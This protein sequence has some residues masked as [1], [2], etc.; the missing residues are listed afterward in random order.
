M[1]HRLSVHPT[2][3]QARLMQQISAGLFKGNVVAMPTDTA[4]ALVCAL[5]NKDA[6]ARLR[7]VRG[8]DDKHHLSLLCPNLSALAT[9]ARVNNP[10]YRLLKAAT[11]GLFTF[12]LDAS[13][14]VP[15]RVS[16]PARKTI[17]LRVPDHPVPL[18]LLAA[19]GQAVIA[20]TLIL[21]GNDTPLDD[22]DEVLQ[23]L[24]GQIDIVVDAGNCPAQP[25]TVVDLTPMAQ[26]QPAQLLRR[27]AGD[28]ALIG[29]ER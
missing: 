12:I 28:P 5:D 11:P 23:A 29:L 3:P 27:G 9:L 22:P 2:H 16:H 4:Y 24:K 21:P 20:S 8:I 17:G 14:E 6:V 26:E 7:R 25:S 15:R 1:T 18:A 19:H 10:Q 13:K